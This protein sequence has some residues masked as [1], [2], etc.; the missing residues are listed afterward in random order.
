MFC[1]CVLRASFWLLSRFFKV[2]YRT[3]FVQEPL[4]PEDQ[5]RSINIQLS[6]DFNISAVS[7]TLLD[8]FTLP[9]PHVSDLTRANRTIPVT[10]FAMR[11]F[12]QLTVDLSSV[13]HAVS[14]MFSY[15]DGFMGGRSVYSE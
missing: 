5:S 4:S 15:S 12:H 9:L 13:E 10:D 8:T 2:L 3:S 11:F 1:P 14:L 7:T 6:R